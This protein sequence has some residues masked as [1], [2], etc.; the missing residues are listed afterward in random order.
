[1]ASGEDV[2]K[3]LD[4]LEQLDTDDL[5]TTGDFEMREIAPISDSL[6]ED[7]PDQWLW[8]LHCNR[9]FQ[10][11]HLRR[12]FLGN[13]QQ[14]AFCQAAGLNVDV[15]IWDVWRTP[16]EPWP[17]STEELRHGMR[18]KIETIVQELDSGRD[19]VACAIVLDAE[20]RYCLC[21]Q[22]GPES[23][24]WIGLSRTE[25]RALKRQNFA[26]MQQL[27]RDVCAN[28]KRFRQRWIEPPLNI[29]R[30][31]KRLA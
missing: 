31:T 27:A 15:F 17:E 14:C 21:V 18:L 13:M 11:R 28:P 23:T 10:A 4:Q 16:N 5:K 7:F 24:I 25:R 1:M 8:C 20:D 30:R 9:F 26:R 19:D 29:D 2:R 3:G 12:D 22:R 6:A